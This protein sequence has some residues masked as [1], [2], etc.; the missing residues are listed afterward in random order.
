MKHRF[1]TLTLTALVVAVPLQ[2]HLSEYS[3]FGP[4][5]RPKQFTVR[6]LAEIRNELGP[7]GAE[8]D[9]AERSRSRQSR[10][11]ILRITWPR[12]KNGDDAGV[13]LSILT[14]DQKHVAGPSH[15]SSNTVTPRGYAGDLNG[16]SVA[17]Y[18]LISPAGGVGAMGPAPAT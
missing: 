10:D 5:E 2:A 8:L 13:A 14:W 16:D 7:K 12:E 1:A 6:D 9:L 15:V 17:D 18:I 11:P 4:S 3:P